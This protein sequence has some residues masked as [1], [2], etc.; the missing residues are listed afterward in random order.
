MSAAP[1][2]QRLSWNLTPAAAAALDRAVAHDGG[3]KTAAVNRALR[4]FAVALDLARPSGRIRVLG[5]D[6][7]VDTVVLA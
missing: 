6:G 1:A 2:G 5:D 7:T 3:D 4:T